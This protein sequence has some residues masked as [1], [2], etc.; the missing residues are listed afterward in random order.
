[1]EV[2]PEL[3]RMIHQAAP[4]HELRQEFR[5]QGGRTLRE[6][7]VMKALEGMSSLEEILRVTHS[8]DSEPVGYVKPVAA[9]APAP[10]APAPAARHDGP[11]REVA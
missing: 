5:R 6:E 10:P 3:R 4:S 11:A 1:M 8:E 7:G 2:G 9:A